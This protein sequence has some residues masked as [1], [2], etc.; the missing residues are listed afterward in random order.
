MKR[1]FQTFTLGLNRVNVSS[2][3]IEHHWY[4]TFPSTQRERMRGKERGGYPLMK[5]K[6]VKKAKKCIREMTWFPLPR[7]GYAREKLDIGPQTETN[8]EF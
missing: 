6:T 3:G 1:V 8:P 2:E 4:Q 7:Q 5:P